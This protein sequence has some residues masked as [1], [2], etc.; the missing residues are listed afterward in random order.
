MAATRSLVGLLLVT[1]VQGVWGSSLGL[2]DEDGTI[3]LSRA[4]FVLFLCVVIV[5][6]CGCVLALCTRV[7]SKTCAC[8]GARSVKPMVPR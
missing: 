2:L 1:T 6:A 8:C 3:G 5:T 4:G 7:W